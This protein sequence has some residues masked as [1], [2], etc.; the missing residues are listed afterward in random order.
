MAKEGFK[1]KLTAILSADVEGYS[2]LM[3]DDEEATIST[4]TEYRKEIA[5]QVKFHKGR[6]VD[7]PGDNV[8]AEFA[9][10]VDAV[11]CAVETQKEITE[12]NANLPENR[13]MQFRIGVNL[14]D[15][16]EEEG[17]IYGDGVNVAA[18][19]EGLAPPGGICISRTTYD[20]IKNKLNL[21]YEY[22]G[23]HSVKNIADPV[24]VY[25]V[26]T[27]PESVGRVIG[28][29]R[30][31][32][33]FSRRTAMAA[34]IILAIVAGGL[35]GWNIYLH[36]SKKV[37]PASL[38]RM[39]FPLPDKPSIAVL[40]FD[41]LT[42]DPNQEYLSD[43]ITEEIITALSKTPKILVIARNSTFTYKG[44]PVK[45]QQVAE[46]LGVQ[47]ILEGSVR[48]D[49]DRLRI[50]TQLIDA[51]SGHHI[52]AERYDRKLEDIFALQDE[53]TLKV[54]AGIHIK[55]KDK[56]ELKYYQ[57]TDNLEAFL[58]V[59]QGR[60][61]LL[62][63]TKAGNISGRELVQ[64]AIELDPEYAAAYNSLAGGLMTSVWFGLSKSP[65]QTLL[66]AIKM[67][68]KAVDI[69]ESFESAH[70]LLAFLYT[71]VRKH[72]FC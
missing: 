11:K 67:A 62:K 7:S 63:F 65:K 42:G 32:G 50:T 68:E 61:H 17:R 59:L 57:G 64:Q 2:R 23:E 43:G 35:I 8:L 71:S 52:W 25:R 66:Q 45:V 26:L 51:L 48:K 12:R 14:G 20:Q 33:R 19:I 54:L 72:D 13:K 5:S 6:V 38:D 39:A 46:E 69:D 58:K 37:E 27:E 56:E 10:V 28:E 47:Y 44:K 24:R 9:S 55:L 21:G 49:D 30:F 70:G 29:K 53:I 22:L 41:N 1:R 16:V 40:P 31:L 60:S 4:L 3:G 15:I 36:Q 34:I 18:R